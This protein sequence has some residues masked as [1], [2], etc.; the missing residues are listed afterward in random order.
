MTAGFTPASSHRRLRSRPRYSVYFNHRLYGASLLGK[1]GLSQT[2]MLS[3][4]A[5]HES[6]VNLMQGALEGLAVPCEAQIRFQIGHSS[7]NIEP[8]FRCR[9]MVTHRVK[10][11]FK[12]D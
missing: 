7:N 9:S 8:W 2:H 3:H 10:K 6:Q 12:I 5:D 4:L 11:T 1:L